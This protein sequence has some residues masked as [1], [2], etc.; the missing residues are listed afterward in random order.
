MAESLGF[1]IGEYTAPLTGPSYIL[2]TLIMRG[3]SKKRLEPEDLTHRK[4]I[5]R[6]KQGTDY[7][8]ASHLEFL[9]SKWLTEDNLDEFKKRL[10]KKG[11]EVCRSW[12]S[13]G[14]DTCK[15]MERELNQQTYFMEALEDD[16]TYSSEM[17]HTTKLSAITV[18]VS[19]KNRYRFDS[20]MVDLLGCVII[21]KVFSHQLNGDFSIKTIGKQ[22]NLNLF[23]ISANQ[24]VDNATKQAAQIL[25]STRDDYEQIYY[26]V[27]SPR[28]CFSF[29]G[30]I[31]NIG[32]TKI[33]HKKMDE[34][35][36]FRLQYWPKQGL[37]YQL[38]SFNGLKTEQIANE[39][40]LQN[41]VK[42]IAPC[43]TRSIYCYPPLANQIWKHWRDSLNETIKLNTPSNIP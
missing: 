9:T 28:W 12:A 36:F 32:A 20:S 10:N 26:P 35:L 41:I 13:N 42:Q 33:L 37:F 31:T 29:E 34:E 15:R 21:L 38:H 1:I 8:I 4:K 14:K 23:V 22:P 17:S 19:E 7:S 39:S 25:K 30:Q 27:L 40:M 24:I 2:Q 43:W 11:E 16:D 18:P 3:H 6:M 5:R